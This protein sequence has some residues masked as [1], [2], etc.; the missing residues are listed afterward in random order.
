MSHSGRCFRSMRRTKRR[1]E[2]Q[3][4]DYDYP[5]RWKV[6]AVIR[7]FLEGNRNQIR[8]RHDQMGLAIARY[9]RHQQLTGKGAPVRAAG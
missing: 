1:K 6:P 7:S 9:A 4:N 8:A 2:A 3:G 5:I